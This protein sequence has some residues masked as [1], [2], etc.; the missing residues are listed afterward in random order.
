MEFIILLK[1]LILTGLVSFVSMIDPSPDWFLG[2]SG[3]DLCLRNCTWAESKIVDLYP[4]DAGTDSG[5]TYTVSYT[6]L[7]TFLNVTYYLKSPDQPTS[8]RDNIRRIRADNPNDPRSPF[9]DHTGTN[10]KPLARLYLSRQ[11]LYEK[12]CPDGTGWYFDH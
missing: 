5:P 10:M 9:Y 8:P 12:D 3:L 7:T 2:V 6:K 1:N 11:R 4:Y